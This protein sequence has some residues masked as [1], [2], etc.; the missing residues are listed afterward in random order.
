MAEPLA[1][2]E[3]ALWRSVIRP[4]TDGASGD[5]VCDTDDHELAEALLA[6]SRTVVHAVSPSGAAG[7]DA[8]YGDRLVVH[9]SASRACSAVRACRLAILDARRELHGH[10]DALRQLGGHQLGAPAVL[11][12]GLGQTLGPGESSIAVL[13]EHGWRLLDLP[14]FD[15]VRIALP[16]GATELER[17]IEAIIQRLGVEELE[18]E[19]ASGQVVELKRRLA[20]VEA[21]REAAERREAAMADTAAALRIFTDEAR[22]DAERAREHIEDLRRRVADAE[23]RTASARAEREKLAGRLTALEGATEA[24]SADL[25]RLRESQSWRLGHAIVRAARVL[26]FRRP[27]RTDALTRAIERLQAQSK[28]SDGA[29]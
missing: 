22:G 23:R 27:G 5:V 3:R 18:D 20:E 10:I 28:E 12:H 25:A 9:G 21:D 26:T 8:V 1:R 7:L 13:S 15:D 16:S 14:G 11:V 29:A 6:V 4:L 24:A 19:E 2:D 17:P